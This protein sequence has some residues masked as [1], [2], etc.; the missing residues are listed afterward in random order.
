[1]NIEEKPY[2]QDLFNHMSNEHGLI[3]TQ[4]EML[5]ILSVCGKE[6]DTVQFEIGETER[7]NRMLSAEN[8][9]L[10]EALREVTS[11]FSDRMKKEG[12]LYGYELDIYR[13][14]KQLITK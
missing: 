6:Y 13:K 14:A 8:E 2:L 3:L 11:Y 10:K 1:M 4:S 12:G 7:Q 9:K 5:E